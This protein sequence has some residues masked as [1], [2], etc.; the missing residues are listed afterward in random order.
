MK[1]LWCQTNFFVLDVGFR[2]RG[3]GWDWPILVKESTKLR[4]FQQDVGFLTRRGYIVP[5]CFIEQELLQRSVAFLY[6]TFN[7]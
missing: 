5:L 6:T 3:F 2:K 4:F 1:R 7:L